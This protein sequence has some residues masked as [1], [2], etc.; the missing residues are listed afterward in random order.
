MNPFF[1]KAITIYLQE[2]WFGRI[3][4]CFTG[5]P[6]QHTRR[7]ATQARE[8]TSTHT[9]MHTRTRAHVAA[10][11]SVSQR[12]ASQ[13]SATQRMQCFAALCCFVWCVCVSLELRGAFSS[14]SAVLHLR[15]PRTLVGPSHEPDKRRITA[16]STSRVTF[17]LG[18]QTF[19]VG[20]AVA[21]LLGGLQFPTGT[22]TMS[23]LLLNVVAFAF[24]RLVFG[25]AL[26]KTHAL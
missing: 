1:Y 22:Y 26:C 14:M 10:Q 2:Y 9:H 12:S 20:I 18:V 16:L 17:Y 5:P 3:G 19:R 21:L 15:G 25:C 6:T 24:V 7:K 13:R 4:P 11:R 23:D 8:H